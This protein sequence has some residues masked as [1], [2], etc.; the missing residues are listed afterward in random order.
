M[1]HKPAFHLTKGLLTSI[2]LLFSIAVFAANPVFI[3]PFG[4]TTYYKKRTSEKDFSYSPAYD[5]SIQYASTG[6]ITMLEITTWKDRTLYEELFINDK[7]LSVNSAWV[8][9]N[10]QFTSIA[11][12]K[13]LRE[14]LEDKASWIFE[15]PETK[16]TLQ[17]TASL[18]EAKF[19]G[20]LP[21]KVLTVTKK[22]K[23]LTIKEVYVEGYGMTVCVINGTIYTQVMADYDIKK[24]MMTT[25]GYTDS[26]ACVLVNDRNGSFYINR[27]KE[28]LKAIDSVSA[29]GDITVPPFNEVTLYNEI[30]LRTLAANMYRHFST[31][32]V[33][34]KAEAFI[35][36]SL[37]S[38]DI[39][40][41]RNTFN[42][43]SQQ[44]N[45]AVMKAL[46]DWFFVQPD[47]DFVKFRLLDNVG[48]EVK[49]ANDTSYISF[50]GSLCEWVRLPKWTHP[51]AMN[52]VDFIYGGINEAYDKSYTGSYRT[53]LLKNLLFKLEKTLAF[54][55]MD[56]AEKDSVY[57]K[58]PAPFYN[59][60]KHTYKCLSYYADNLDS[61]ANTINQTPGEEIQTLA[62]L[63]VNQ[64]LEQSSLP[65]DKLWL[66]MMRLREPAKAFTIFKTA[67]KQHTIMY[68]VY[69]DYVKQMAEALHK[70]D[71]VVSLINN[72]HIEYDGFTVADKSIAFML[73][74]RTDSAINLI[75]K[76][77]WGSI[78]FFCDENKGQKLV[79]LAR[80]KKDNKMLEFFYSEIKNNFDL[81]KV[82][83]K[84]YNSEKY[85]Q[86]VTLSK[87]TE[88]AGNYELSH[89]IYEYYTK[90]FK[91][92]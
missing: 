36:R 19:T 9:K 60:C 27:I 44:S 83:K 63:L 79:R 28:S 69:A 1:S 39:R 74:N 7:T 25:L 23:G 6:G 89:K 75:N 88:E 84:Q 76:V 12:E 65:S 32:D 58:S 77:T 5:F 33:G 31:T 24:D 11:T 53:P 17:C 70:E 67:I 47:I 15:D 73:L 38:L 85:E 82:P 66:L 10:N 46:R 37:G 92:R 57:I 22:G 45:P 20:M 81:D 56:K 14:K 50:A 91:Y 4:S 3:S 55:Y 42:N 68:T 51:L 43:Q 62:Q 86:L 35:F 26:L 48:P 72:N 49:P 8:K 21:R 52:E 54:F 34:E 13:N 29:L 90:M 30:K 80:E 41:I 61:S 71:E 64:G 59:A 78:Y 16:I 40:V 87:L 2:V 18:S